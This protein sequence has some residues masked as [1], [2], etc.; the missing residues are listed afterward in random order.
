MDIALGLVGLVA[1]LLLLVWVGLQIRPAPFAPF[2]QISRTPQVRPLPQGLPPPVARFYQQIY[3]DEIPVI[4]SAVIT[5]HAD[6]RPVGPVTI[7]AR[8][9]ITHLAGQGYRHYFEAGLYGLPMIRV[10]ERYLD[11]RARG[12]TP[13]GIDEGERIDQA[14]N[15]GLWAETIWI[16]A[17]FLTDPRVEW[18]AVNDHTA[19]LT[20][21]F[22]NSRDQFLVRFSPET[23]LVEWF[24][25]MRYQKQ[26]SATKILWLNQSL[27]WKPLNGTL[28]NTIG[29]ATWMDDGKPWAVF[30]VEDIRLNVDVEEHIR[31][32]GP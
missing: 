7:P 6:V 31:A 17:V 11:G 1:L 15:L 4:T 16:P 22:G 14:A 5:G 27:E 8:F 10:D 28:T 9:R 29:S 2:P 23:G 30:Y 20:I 21:P 13:F 24:E 3:G 26:A 19:L 12:I 25:S 32:Q 18:R